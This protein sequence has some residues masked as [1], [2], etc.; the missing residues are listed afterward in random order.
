M[1]QVVKRLELIS[2]AIILE[3]NDIITSQTKKLRNFPLDQE[4]L[5]ITKMLEK[6]SYEEAIPKIKNYLKKFVDIGAY[7]DPLVQGIKLEIQTFEQDITA[8]AFT[9]YNIL[10][11][12]LFFNTTYQSTLGSIIQDILELKIAQIDKND[13][14]PKEAKKV[15]TQYDKLIQVA[16]QTTPNQNTLSPKELEE[17]EIAYK[18]LASIV[19]PQL[20]V[21]EFQDEANTI[22][23]NLNQAYIKQDLRGIKTISSHLREGADYLYGIDK[24]EDKKELRKYSKLLRQHI[25][26]LED[27]LVQLQNTQIVPLIK[28]TQTIESFF[29]TTKKELLA[30]KARLQQSVLKN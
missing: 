25:K 24:L 19:N 28:D 8:L 6:H 23:S 7:K 20:V 4:A 3:E 29:A 9:K 21:Q 1:K 16:T 10:K 26:S 22:Y 2:L 11:N 13:I 17:L 5:S 18:K 12:I 30:K 14:K 27:E 15:K